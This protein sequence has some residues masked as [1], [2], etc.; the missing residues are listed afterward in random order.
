MCVSL[1]GDTMWC[2]LWIVKWCDSLENLGNEDRD[3]GRSAADPALAVPSE[4]WEEIF[5]KREASAVWDEFE[6]PACG[7]AH[8]AV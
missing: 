6:C 5:G 7:C 3:H 1:I 4:C 8:G 2:S